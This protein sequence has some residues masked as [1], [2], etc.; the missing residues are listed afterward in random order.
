[1]KSN[2]GEAPL[3]VSSSVDSLYLWWGR[4]DSARCQRATSDRLVD[5]LQR[6]ALGADRLQ[7]ALNIKKPFCPMTCSL[8]PPITACGH[9]VR[10]ARRRPIDRPTRKLEAETERE[11]EERKSS[12]WRLRPLKC[13][14]RKC[15]S[16]SVWRR[17]TCAIARP[18]SKRFPIGDLPR[19]ERR[20]RSLS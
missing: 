10:F 11:P 20:N 5:R 14:S 19:H 17:A 3:H 16:R 12:G 6:I 9:R 15:F 4:S 8:H 7:S 2:K 1:M 18:A 13:F